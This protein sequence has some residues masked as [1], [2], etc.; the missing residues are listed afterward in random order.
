MLDGLESVSEGFGEEKNILP[1]PGF[2]PSVVQPL[3]ILFREVGTKTLRKLDARYE[4][5]RI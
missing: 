5:E 4:D 3:A 2:E 1:F